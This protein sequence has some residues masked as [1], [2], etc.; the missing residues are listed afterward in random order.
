MILDFT[1]LIL[2]STNDTFIIVILLGSGMFSA[3]D[4]KIG[5]AEQ[6]SYGYVVSQMLLLLFKG[7]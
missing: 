5:V 1:V 4:K 3:T 6:K 7:L 2:A